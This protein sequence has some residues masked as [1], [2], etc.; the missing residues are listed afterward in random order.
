MH[1]ARVFSNSSFY[2]KACSGAL[3][4]GWEK[5]INGIN[6]PLLILGDPAHPLLPWL[7]K[8]YL[9]TASTTPQENFLNYRAEQS[10]DG[11]GE[12]M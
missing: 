5:A 12:C 10:K 6:V 11:G 4:P 8:P 3:F 2:R 7:M 1:D 9:E